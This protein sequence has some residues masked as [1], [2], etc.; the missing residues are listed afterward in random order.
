MRP[1]ARPERAFRSAT[2]VHLKFVARS[3]VVAALPGSCDAA[4]SYVQR[5]LNRLFCTTRTIAHWQ[6]GVRLH[7]PRSSASTDSTLSSAGATLS[8]YPWRI[9]DARRAPVVKWGHACIPIARERRPPIETSA[10]GLIPERLQTVLKDGEFVLC[11]TGDPGGSSA[12]RSVL[13]MMPR[14]EHPRP[15]TVRMLEHE[16]SLRDELDPLWAVRPVALTMHDGRTALVLEDPGGEPLTQVRRHT[17]HDC[18]GP[19]CGCRCVGSSPAPARPRPHSQGPQTGQ[20]DDRLAKRPS[21][22]EGLRH[23][24][25]DPSR[26][27][28][29]GTAG[30]HHR[31]ARLYGAGANGLDES[32][33]RCP[34]R[35]LC[36]WRRAV[37][38]VDRQSAVHR[39]RSD[40]VGA[41]PHRA[42]AG[43][44]ERA[45]ARD[46][47]CGLGD[48]DEAARQDRRG[49]LSDRRRLSSTTCGAASRSGKADGRI[50]AFPLAEHDT[51]DRLVIPEKLYGRAREIETLLGAF[52]RLVTSG[53]PEL[54]LVSG[55]SGI[56]KSSVVNEL[57][58][59]LVPPRGLFA[60]GKFDQYKRD[61]PYATLAQAFQ[62][63]VRNLL[64][65]SDAELSGWRDALARGAGPEWA[66]DD[67]PRPGAQ[68]DHRRPASSS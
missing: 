16:Y 29:A 44:A 47:G 2:N 8:S 12:S 33:D 37:R 52:E 9:E 64:G 50:D 49:S 48:R 6:T 21:L 62:S 7:A 5:D 66:T 28:S 55:Y 39:V 19:P 45:A 4:V 1:R 41:R 30:V 68:A 23:R 40:G 67:R 46:T 24:D 34:Q 43:A 61:I 38:T 25:S 60:S 10:A 58:K 57:H 56:G 26:A 32:V 65:K 11:R 27:S 20:R 54:V 36:S 13:V 22:A 14:S 35:P 18:R 51:P 17:D 63:L 3:G 31:N 59:V 53:T 15:Q 42:A